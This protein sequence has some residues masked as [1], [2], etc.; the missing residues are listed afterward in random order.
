MG[1]FADYLALTVGAVLPVLNP[2]G[3]SLIFLG[4]VGTAPRQVFTMLARRV[5]FATFLFLLATDVAGAAVLRAFG[6]SL[7]VVQLGGGIVIAAM[8]WE[9]LNKNDVQGQQHASPHMA[10]TTAL[11]GMIFYP[12]TFP[13]TAGPGVM[14]VMLTLSAHASKEVLPDM[15]FAQLGVLAAMVLLSLTVFVFYAYAP[16]LTARISVSTAHGILRVVSFILF[17]IGVQIAWN[18]LSA[19][20]AAEHFVRH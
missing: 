16:V 13:I 19:L 12:F 1:L 4:M 15:L 11:R 6:I 2:V 17:C 20:M 14:V 5:A 8:G 18:G 10:D 9:L 3:S 7:P